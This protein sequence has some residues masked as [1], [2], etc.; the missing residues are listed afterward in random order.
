MCSDSGSN[1]VLLTSQNA[2]REQVGFDAKHYL[3]LSPV[4]DLG[5][6]NMYSI[7]SVR[8]NVFKGSREPF[9]SLLREHGI[10]YEEHAPP[11]GV[12]FAAGE[13]VEVAKSTAVFGSLAA[14]V[15]AFLK[16]RHGRK[17][18]ITT[19][20]NTVVHAEGLTHK[21]LEKV[22]ELASNVTAIDRG[23]DET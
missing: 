8:I 2:A 22:L 1:T 16:H 5:Q 6:R 18:I 4:I 19:K 17:V 11:I 13:W 12:V 20:D 7:Q 10:E 14:V 9:L 21:E 15:V 3:N 23:T